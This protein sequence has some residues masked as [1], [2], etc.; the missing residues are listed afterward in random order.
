MS[1]TITSAQKNVRSR[2]QMVRRYQQKCPWYVNGIQPD[3]C[4]IQ[5]YRFS[6]IINGHI[7][8][9]NISAEK[10]AIAFTDGEEISTEMPLVC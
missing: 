8:D 7:T 9:Y 2:V 5:G 1:P 6:P 10:C 4:F 3:I